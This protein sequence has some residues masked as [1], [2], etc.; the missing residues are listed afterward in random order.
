MKVPSFVRSSSAFC[1]GLVLAMSLQTALAA[2]TDTP[3][4]GSVSPNFYGVTIEDTL[5]VTGEVA[6]N[7]D[8]FYSSPDTVYLGAIGDKN[9]DGGVHINKNDGTGYGSLYGYDG[10]IGSL[11]DRSGGSAIWGWNTNTDKDVKAIQGWIDSGN[12]KGILGYRDGGLEHGVYGSNSDG[13]SNESGV[14]GTITMNSNAVGGQTTQ[15][16]TGFLGYIDKNNSLYGVYT[17]GTI[18]GTTLKAADTYGAVYTDNIIADSTNLSV[19]ATGGTNFSGPVTAEKF[20]TFSNTSNSTSS[21]SSV[22]QSCN[23]GQTLISC[24]G[25]IS[26]SNDTFLGAYPASS[27]KCTAK[28]SGTNGTLYVYAYCFDPTT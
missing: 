5:D 7:N 8:R 26:S 27:R 12:T 4:N 9:V 11:V 16:T 18:Y 17:S 13:S 20:G 14:Q 15:S 23:S 3:P 6:F 19:T 10:Y 2:P 25:S 22:S 1:A 24:S 28:R 21:A